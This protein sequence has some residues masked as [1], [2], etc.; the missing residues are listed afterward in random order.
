MGVGR[1]VGETWGAASRR[2]LGLDQGL[3]ADGKES[4]PVCAFGGSDGIFFFLKFS[5]LVGLKV[6]GGDGGI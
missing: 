6:L 3:G 1:R 2:K 5:F 4:R